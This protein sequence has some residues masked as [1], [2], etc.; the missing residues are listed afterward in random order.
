MEGGKEVR[1]AGLEPTTCRLEG[2]CSIQLSYGRN[3]LAGTVGTLP[4]P[5]AFYTRP[6]DGPSRFTSSSI[7]ARSRRANPV[8][9]SDRIETR[10][11]SHFT[12]PLEC[13]MTAR[14]L[15]SATL[16]ARLLRAGRRIRTGQ[17]GHEAT[18][19]RSSRRKPQTQASR[20]PPRTWPTARSSGRCSTSGRPSPTS[21]RRSSST[22]T[23]AAGTD[24][25]KSGY[26]GRVKK[27]LDNGISV[28]TI[29][30]R[31]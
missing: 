31:L 11:H 30:Y 10:R 28:A 13:T 4:T 19:Q 29:N 26:Y 16:A 12:H 23:A 9:P 2:G 27:F 24:G 1:P 6:P 25:D 3:P 18:W 20:R 8:V 7:R 15:L 22:S 21:R 17:E 14:R 5:S